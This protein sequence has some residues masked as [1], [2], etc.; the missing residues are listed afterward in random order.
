MIERVLLG[1]LSSMAWLPPLWAQQPLAAP[2]PARL[3]LLVAVGEYEQ[4]ATFRRLRGVRHDVAL[5]RD[6]LAQRFAFTDAD[7][8]TLVDGEAT[9]EAFLRAFDA[10]L[11]R[12]AGKDTQVVVFFACH[13]SMIPDPSGREQTVQGRPRDSSLV[14]FDSR[15]GKRD[16][17][18]DLSD[19]ALAALLG[20]V[21][22]KGAH[23]TLLTDACHSGGVVRG[24]RSGEARFAGFGGEAVDDPTTWPGWPQG[25]AFADDGPD[26]APE[27]RVVH[28]SACSNQQI[29]YEYDFD[30]ASGTQT[31]GVFTF[32]L[33]E[34]LRRLQPGDTFA[35]L[36]RRVEMAMREVPGAVFQNPW[37]IGAGAHKV[38][39]GGFGGAAQGF[40]LR[41]SSEG[42][43]SLDAG[44]LHGLAVGA[45][46]NV[47][48]VGTGE[49]MGSVR[50]SRL[51][52][53]TSGVVWVDTTEVARAAHSTPSKAP[54]QAV[55]ASRPDVLTRLSVFTD[56]PEVA[57]RHR[58]SRWAEVQSDRT[59]R[60]EYVLETKP[61]L[62]LRTREGLVLWPKGE[63]AQDA[64]VGAALE[65]ALADEQLFQD[66]WR[67]A[68][69]HVRG[70]LSQLKVAWRAPN[71]VELAARERDLLPKW[72]A[73][74]VQQ[75]KNGDATV[76][77]S[78]Y[79]AQEAA[80]VGALSLLEIT[81][82][83]MQRVFVTVIN[84]SES[85]SIAVM[86][87][88][89]KDHPMQEDGAIASKRVWLGAPS[90][91]DWPLSRPMRDRY[92][93]I[94][95]EKFVDFSGVERGT[96][97]GVG[98][99][100]DVPPVLRRAAGVTRGDHVSVAPGGWGV[101]WVDLCVQ[102]VGGG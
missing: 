93:V 59:D 1:V 53:G 31:H 43:L 73:A 35:V 28:L 45:E 92:L 55:L 88:S 94:A 86:P 13:G 46:L 58:D 49:A 57:L 15:H 61:A 72:L 22:R 6:V 79:A 87:V 8:L 48:A 98:E 29:A 60:G 96:E 85:R 102:R 27:E 81:N 7:T 47:H 4:S 10:H 21:A 100:G 23:V 67:L 34:A 74:P 11:L 75:A 52:Y 37:L 69:D 56:D 38:L 39:A 36:T 65:K 54:M 89:E 82:D 3:A 18:F 40:A 5:V 76:S 41:S 2:A 97:R 9:L 20:A 30:T 64:D 25:V 91:A 78:D 50:V 71:E 95:T 83:T 42:T 19:D 101:T 51:G 63:V 26:D 44:Y 84:L 33:A 90:A 80:K 77:L 32:C 14:L 16:G 70:K 24:G 62:R 17:A 99:V 66:L 12:R 68:N